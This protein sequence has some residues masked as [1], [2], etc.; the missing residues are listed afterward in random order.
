MTTAL[1]PGRPQIARLRVRTAR[2][3]AL[4]VSLRAGALLERLDLIPPGLPPS[5]V[6]LVRALRDPLP[7]CV[8]FAQPGEAAPARWQQ[9]LTTSMAR[10]AHEAAR[11]ALGAVPTSAA[12]VLFADEAELVACLVRDWLGGRV[13]DCWWWRSVLG[14]QAPREWLRRRVLERGELMVPAMAVLAAGRDAAAWLARLDDTEA[15]AAIAAIERSHAVSLRAVAE[16]STAR[17]R[18]GFIKMDR[19]AS[20]RPRA[21]ERL[22]EVVPE[23]RAPQLRQL[24]RR[25]AALVL[26]LVRAPLWARSSQLALAVHELERAGPGAD[27]QA[28]EIPEAI[29]SGIAV[30]RPARPIDMTGAVQVHEPLEQPA[31][32]PDATGG[33]GGSPARPEESAASAQPRED[34]EPLQAQGG[35]AERSAAIARTVVEAPP[36]QAQDSPVVPA[37]SARSKDVSAAEQAA[38]IRTKFGGIFYLLNAALALKLYADFTSPRGS[39][40]R[41]SPWD[42]LALI[43]RDWFGR[44][45]VRDPVWKLL[46]GLAGR[47]RRRL[48]RPRWLKSQ[49]ESLLARLALALGEEHS[50]DIPA[51]VCRHPAEI[52]ATASRVDVH[53]ALSDLALALRIAGLDRDPG[54]IPAAGRS[55]AFHFE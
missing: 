50:A 10:F 21:F 49:I 32:S 39:N 27:G 33:L 14:D 3:D 55:I 29:E 53:L 7:G 34:A 31:E 37:P 8:S 44:E 38:R 45:F 1:L 15:A 46:A 12:A 26:A 36:M 6:L 9:A 20:S 28:R 30:P 42:W 43:G 52:A 17:P 25:L 16:D 5:S 51:F 47:E 24:Q 48:R 19:R 22:V 23:V 4:Q 18:D 41:I 35:Q 54:W 40:L 11:P 13:A 2:R